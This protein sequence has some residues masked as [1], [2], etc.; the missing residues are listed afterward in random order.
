[1]ITRVGKIARLPHA[2]RDELN[3]RLANGEPGRTVLAWLNDLYQV[4]ALLEDHFR[5]RPISA[6][7]LS[8]WKQGGFV[9]WQRCQE[10]RAVARGFVIEAEELE[11]EFDWVTL[12]DRLASLAA[13]TLGQM[14]RA[15]M[16]GDAPDRRTAIF[17]ILRELD[18]LRRGNHR[19]QRVQFQTRRWNIER[20]DKLEA[21]KKAEDAAWRE[22]GRKQAAAVYEQA[23]FREYCYSEGIRKGTMSARERELEEEH[24]AAHPQLHPNW[25][26]TAAIAEARRDHPGAEPCARA[27]SPKLQP[28]NLPRRI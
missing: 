19:M 26:R 8:E 9:D 4:K 18:R 24:F 21:I 20:E 27:R 6:Q 15:A 11:A 17:E 22:E 5:S 3:L 7:N 12:A 14:L 13:V 28:A 10:T 25:R 1:M 23:D 16:A 2:I